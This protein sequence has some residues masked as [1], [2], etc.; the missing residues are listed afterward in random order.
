MQNYR[1]LYSTIRNHITLA[2]PS[3]PD[4]GP[5]PRCRPDALPYTRAVKRRPPAPAPALARF[6]RALI[7]LELELRRLRF[8]LRL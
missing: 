4:I 3:K 5:Q 8:L 1:L 7:E 6:S 2:R